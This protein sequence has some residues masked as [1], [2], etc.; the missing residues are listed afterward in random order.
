MSAEPITSPTTWTELETAVL[1][2]V[3]DNDEQEFTEAFASLREAED[4]ARELNDL[5][6]NSYDRLLTDV[7]RYV[8]DQLPTP[9]PS[10]AIR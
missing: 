7:D 5:Y 9:W 3:Y 10:W 1:Y 6:F 8:V 2:A 4:R